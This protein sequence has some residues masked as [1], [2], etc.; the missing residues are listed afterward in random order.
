MKFYPFIPFL[1][2]A[3]GAAGQGAQVI[4]FAELAFDRFYPLIPAT[5]GKLAL[6]EP[7]PGPTTE[8]FAE[9]A[10][11]LGN[12]VVLNL[13]DSSD[14]KTFINGIAARSRLRR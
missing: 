7:I 12:V 10:R 13:F 6:A 4:C 1:T 3:C 9:L 14:G 2:A 5:P 8:V 11:E